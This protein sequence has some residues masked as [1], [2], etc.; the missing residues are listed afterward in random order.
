MAKKITTVSCYYCK[1]SGIRR[2]VENNEFL[3]ER[4]PVCEGTGSFTGEVTCFVC[5]GDGFI[6]PGDIRDSNGRAD[7]SNL[8]NCFQCG[9]SGI[10]EEAVLDLSRGQ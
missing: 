9:G 10:D 1:G 2:I 5:G 7:N 3:E 4:C 6:K 8:G